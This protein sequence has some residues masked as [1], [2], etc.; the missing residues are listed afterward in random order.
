MSRFTPII[1]V[2]V[3][4]ALAVG[5]IVFAV[6]QRPPAATT[7]APGKAPATATAPSGASPQVAVKGAEVEQRDKLGKLQWKVTA[8]GDLQ[9]DKGRQVAHGRDVQFQIM[10]ADKPNIL[11]RATSF[12]ANYNAK[13][14]SFEQG[15]SGRLADGSG[16]FSV[17]RLEYDL[18]TKKLV[19]SGGA[20]FTQGQ[21]TATA[22]EIVLDTAHTKVRMRGGVQFSKSR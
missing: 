8:S 2:V 5:L 11:I 16:E 4:L 22:P 10:Q 21:Y 1:I 7:P 17:Q 15:V 6:R 9:F 12:E 20:R 18:T 13:K 19:G 14:L 3:A